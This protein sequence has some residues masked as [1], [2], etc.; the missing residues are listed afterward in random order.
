VTA[1]REEILCG[2]FE[3]GRDTNLIGLNC[4]AKDITHL[5]LTIDLLGGIEV[6]AFGDDLNTTE[7]GNWP[8]EYIVLKIEKIVQGGEI[9]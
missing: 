6:E 2:W 1:D 3:E 9:V 7:P 4:A 5:V 8:N